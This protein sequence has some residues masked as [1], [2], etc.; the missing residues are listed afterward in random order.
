MNVLIVYAHHEPFSFT[1]ALK[2]VAVNVLGGLGN[3]VTVSDLYGQGFNAVAQK[4]DFVSTSG[5]H[6]NYMLEQRH[7]ARLDFAFSP[8]IVSE[9]EKLRTAD[10]VLFIAPLWWSSVPAIVKGWFDRVMAMGVAWDGDKIYENGLL[11]GKQAM[12]V[13]SAGGPPDYFEQEGPLK[14]TATQMLHPINHG[15]LAFCGMNVH[16][17]YLISNV[18]GLSEEQLNLHLKEF[19][20]RLEHLDD[21]PQWL[22]NFDAS[23]SPPPSSPE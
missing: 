23:L 16:E 13:L 12:L 17:P 20:F 10:L 4:W 1:S 21:S 15:V 22:V 14:A 18:L 11:R 5:G 19:Q 7:S 3:A 2:N 8:D 6:F 9:I